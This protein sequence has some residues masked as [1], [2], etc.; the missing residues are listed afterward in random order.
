MKFKRVCIPETGTNIFLHAFSADYANLP[1]YHLNIV[2]EIR[3]AQVPWVI[4][5]FHYINDFVVIDNGKQEVAVML[6]GLAR[7]MHTQR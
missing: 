4:I 6:E 1:S 5:S 2:L 3:I 7:C